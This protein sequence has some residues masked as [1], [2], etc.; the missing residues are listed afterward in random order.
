MRK[1]IK[2]S[3]GKTIECE[4]D[5][6]VKLTLERENDRKKR[7]DK[8]LVK[9]P[10]PKIVRYLAARFLRKFGPTMKRKN[11]LSFVLLQFHSF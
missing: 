9:E 7:D 10:F 4:N 3:K 2:E 1:T 11:S 8:T 6:T 5:R